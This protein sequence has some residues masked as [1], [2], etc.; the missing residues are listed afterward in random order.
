MHKQGFTLIELLV[1]I[2]IIGILAAFALPQYLNAVAHS[3]YSQLQIAASALRTAAQRYHLSTGAWPD[4]FSVLDIS[5]QGEVSEDGATL[6]MKDSFCEYY[7]DENGADPMLACFSSKSPEVGYLSFYNRE[8]RYCLA[9]SSDK[10][11][12]H[13][14]LSLEGELVTS[15]LNDMEQYSIP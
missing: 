14:C 3:R 12:Q 8:E 7:A 5:F 11:A 10:K 9:P 6:T 1:V 13:F 15:E 2:L 4:D